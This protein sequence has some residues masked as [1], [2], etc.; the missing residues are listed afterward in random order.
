M[1][2]PRT[3]PS[4]TLD[5]V[6]DALRARQQALAE[7][8]ARAALW[9]S[10]VRDGQTWFCVGE[11]RDPDALRYVTQKQHPG[12]QV[13]IRLVTAGPPQVSPGGVV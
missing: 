12:K 5:E 13:S 8:E 4:R 2:R 7:Q 1:M 3:T 9:A 10:W 11:G 6:L